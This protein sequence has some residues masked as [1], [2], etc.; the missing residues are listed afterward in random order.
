MKR[1]YLWIII[2]ILLAGFILM[3]WIIRDILILLDKIE[4]NIIDFINE[5]RELIP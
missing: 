3:S 5:T 4:S 1:E 2:I